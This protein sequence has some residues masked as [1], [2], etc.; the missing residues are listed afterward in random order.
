[1]NVHRA[2]YLSLKETLGELTR[3][4]FLE[5]HDLLHQLFERG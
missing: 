1:M 3:E 4:E 2:L 5:Y